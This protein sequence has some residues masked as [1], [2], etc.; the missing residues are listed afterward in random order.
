[1]NWDP[2]E[3]P[4]LDFNED[5]YSVLDV[6]NTVDAKELKKAYY[7]LVF[8][9]HPDNIDNAKMKETCN[10]QM[11]VINGAYKIL[12]VVNLRALYDKQR[13]RGL[14]GIGT[15]VK[16]N[17]VSIPDTPPSRPPPQRAPPSSPGYLCSLLM[18]YWTSLC[19]L[20]RTC[21]QSSLYETL[22]HFNILSKNHHHQPFF[23]FSRV[24]CFGYL[25]LGCSVIS[26]L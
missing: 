4:K 3:F 5:Y 15:G 14:S 7:K 9:Y 1:M 11:M 13:K 12:K 26:L 25:L 2:K 17:S 21:R 22:F 8:K 23:I 18:P 6:V 24:E 20:R 10:K 19:V 16:E